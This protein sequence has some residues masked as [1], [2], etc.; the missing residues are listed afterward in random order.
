MFI[1]SSFIKLL[2]TSSKELKLSLNLSKSVLWHICICDQI[3]IFPLKCE[4]NFILSHEYDFSQ[5]KI[6]AIHVKL[7][8]A[9]FIN[10]I[11][12]WFIHRYQKTTKHLEVHNPHVCNVVM[13]IYITLLVLWLVVRS[14]EFLRV[15][16]L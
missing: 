16:S 2:R 4:S 5:C 11:T 15:H 14:K 12:E 13:S 1:P 3:A 9:P 8:C 10:Y 6:V 7:K